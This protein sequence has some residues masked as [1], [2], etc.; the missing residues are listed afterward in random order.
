[1]TSSANEPHEV[2]DTPIGKVGM[3]VCWDLAFPEAFREL[4]K[5]GVDLVI[6]PTFCISPFRYVDVVSLRVGNG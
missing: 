4:A 3:L 1:M 2:F 6:I 5:K